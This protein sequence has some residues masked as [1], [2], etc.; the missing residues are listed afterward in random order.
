MMI[1][2][3][4][5]GGCRVAVGCARGI[6][7]VALVS[8]LFA[9][10]LGC[11]SELEALRLLEELELVVV[12]ELVVSVFLLWDVAEAL[13]FCFLGTRALAAFW[14]LVFFSML[15]AAGVCGPLLASS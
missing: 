11:S 4:S 9:E 10:A 3:G 12:L 7:G 2:P 1:S 8:T 6:K 14:A 5:S 15:S 13:V